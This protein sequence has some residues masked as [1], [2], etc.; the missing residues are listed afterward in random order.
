VFV[1]GLANGL[2]VSLLNIESV[3]VTLIMMTVVQG[4]VF[5]LTK[6]GNTINL[7]NPL[8]NMISR[9]TVLMIPNLV[10]I[11]VFVYLVSYTVLNH[12]KLGFYLVAI[13][14]NREGARLAGINVSR[15]ILF[16]FLISGFFMGLVAMLL[17]ARILYVTPTIGG[18]PLLLDA[19]AAAII[20]GV[21]IGGG[22]GTVQGVFIGSLAIALINNSINLMD[23]HPSWNQFF[24]GLT[25]LIMMLAN[26]YLEILEIRSKLRDRT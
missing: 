11:M 18:T 15:Y 6:L 26:R 5:I 3:I 24:K 7:S 23:I 9:G 17:A 25:I 12:T 19:I 13:G 21:A 14:N 22:K 10:I 1:L 20:G 2:L 8:Y 4:L 16:S